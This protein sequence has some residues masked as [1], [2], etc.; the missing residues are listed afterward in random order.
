[1]SRTRGRQDS[2]LGYAD[3]HI[4]IGP[5]AFTATTGTAA[6]TRNAS[7][8]FSLNIGASQTAVLQC[9]LDRL[10]FRY[11]VQDWLQ[12]QFGSAQAGG[13]QG[14]PVGGYSTLTTASATAGSSVNVAVINSGNF[15]NGR[16]VSAG[17]QK[18]QI[19]AIPDATHITL[20]T[21]TVTLAAGS[22]ISENLFTTPAGVTGPPPLTGTTSLTPVTSP[23]PKGIAFRE[24]YPVYQLTGAAASL[25][26]IGLTKT[27]FA[28]AT[29]PVVTNLL[30]DAANGLA[31]A[32]QATPYVTPIQI[33]SPAV[34]QTTKFS[35]YMLEWDVTTAAGGAARIYGV[36]IDV[37]YNFS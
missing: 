30:T 28:N 37:L 16:F 36:F 18:T 6:L 27:V 14:L 15:T 9:P 13:S 1:M 12:E 8:D 34:Y 32:T 21:L 25:N 35:E 2:D 7:G 19:V 3:G 17:T 24:L 33:A 4:F 23:R 31:T 10:I 29:A 11:G 26:T 22:L 20:A 5:E